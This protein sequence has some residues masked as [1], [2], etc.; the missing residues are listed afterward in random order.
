MMVRG[1]YHAYIQKALPENTGFR[2]F[3]IRDQDKLQEV[4]RM[5]YEV[6]GQYIQV[7]DGEVF[8][9]A[10]IYSQESPEICMWFLCFYQKAYF[11]AISAPSNNNAQKAILTTGNGFD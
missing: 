4:L 11:G 5:L 2:A 7:G 8:Q 10:Y 6:G 9:C 3:S 1:L